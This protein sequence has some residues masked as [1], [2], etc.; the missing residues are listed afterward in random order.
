MLR[1]LFGQIGIEIDFFDAVGLTAP[2]ED[3]HDLDVPVV[4]V[5][6]GLPIACQFTFFVAG[7]RRS[8][9]HQMIRGSDFFETAKDATQQSGELATV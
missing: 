1:G 7:I 8:M 2:P 5:R 4:I 3:R 9:N 6:K